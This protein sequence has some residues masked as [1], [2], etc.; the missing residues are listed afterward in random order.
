[1]ADRDS[2]T[3][4]KGRR[5][6]T[7]APRLGNQERRGW[8]LVTVE[9]AAPKKDRSCFLPPPST[10]LTFSAYH[11][12]PPR[13]PCSSSNMPATRAQSARPHQRYSPVAVSNPADNDVIIL[14]SDDEQPLKAL[15]STPRRKRSKQ[16]NRA[17]I[18]PT[19][20]VV[21]IS[22]GEEDVVVTRTRFPSRHQTDAVASLQQQLK[23]AQEVCP[24]TFRV[25]ATSVYRRGAC[26]R[27]S[28]CVKKPVQLRNRKQPLHQ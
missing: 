15:P 22:S 21:E 26:R 2:D 7:S 19:A 12:H 23:E 14:S 24:N 25:Y 11:H 27:S 5:A 8:A 10:P 28:D 9:V 13:L 18:P 4:Q 3:S 16:K 6:A 1:M 20:D 17:P